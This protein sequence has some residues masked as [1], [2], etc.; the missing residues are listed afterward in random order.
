ML[1]QTSFEVISSM[2]SLKLIND[3]I[4]KIIYEQTGLKVFSNIHQEAPDKD[5]FSENI[6]I[7]LSNEGMIFITKINAKDIPRAFKLPYFI[8]KVKEE[9]PQMF[10]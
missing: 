10:I 9:H 7:E 5:P 4:E 3:G 2:P 6:I 1:Y 8:N